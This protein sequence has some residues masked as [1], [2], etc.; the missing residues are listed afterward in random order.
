MLDSCASLKEEHSAEQIDM[1]K[2]CIYKTTTTKR[3][4]CQWR[5]VIQLAGSQ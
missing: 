2:M 5:E 3:L 4:P 1:T